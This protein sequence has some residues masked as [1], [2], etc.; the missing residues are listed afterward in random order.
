M[1]SGLDQ[2]QT[3]LAVLVLAV[4]LQ[5]LTDGDSLLD[6]V[7]QILRNVGLQANRLHDAQDLVSVNETHLGNAVRV[8]EDDAYKQ[9]GEKINITSNNNTSANTDFGGSQTLLA[10]L[11]NLI[12]DIF[13][14]QLQPR[15]HGASV[16]QSRLG[17]TLAAK[18]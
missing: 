6:H 2:N 16:G 5:M 11:L 12:L 7:V 15:R 8:T 13:G 17:N 14:V 9:Y 3:E 10:Q 18:K 4:T 1:N